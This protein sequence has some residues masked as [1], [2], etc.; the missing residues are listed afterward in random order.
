MYLSR[1]KRV[2]NSTYAPLDCAFEPFTNM[3]AN[4]LNEANIV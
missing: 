4:A 3:L 2:F 1:R